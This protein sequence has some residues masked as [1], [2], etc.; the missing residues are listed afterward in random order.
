MGGGIIS[1][2][3]CLPRITETVIQGNSADPSGG[4][5]GG[6]VACFSGGVVLENCLI[7]DNHSSDYAISGIKAPRPVSSTARLP[8]MPPL[9]SGDSAPRGRSLLRSGTA[10]CETRGSEIE[11]GTLATITYSD[12]EGGYAG[13]GNIDADPLFV[14][15]A[16]DYHLAAASPC[17]DAGADE[18]TLVSDLDGTVRPFGSGWDMGAYESMVS[19]TRPARYEQTDSR[20]TYSGPW[21]TSRAPRSPAAPTPRVAPRPPHWSSSTAPPST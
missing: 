10:S 21:A 17:I 19:T 15:P 3:G 5:K 11:P 1:E 2:S 6:A 13:A 9:A 12:V 16:A 14:D 20:V 4:G 8:T 18:T 7:T